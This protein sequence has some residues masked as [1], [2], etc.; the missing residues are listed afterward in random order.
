MKR[1]VIATA[2]ILAATL[3]SGSAF[4]IPGSDAK[5]LEAPAAT[6]NVNC[7]CHHRPHYHYRGSC[8]SGYYSLYTYVTP[9]PA[10]CGCG[11]CGYGGY[12]L[13]CGGFFGGVFGW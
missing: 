5:S 8:C 12:T 11:G 13:R 7:G 6:L 2:A 3:V 1:L 4:A 9:C 10:G